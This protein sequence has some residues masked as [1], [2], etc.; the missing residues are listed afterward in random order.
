VGSLAIV[1]SLPDVVVPDGALGLKGE[2]TLGD[3]GLSLAMKV[4]I[5]PTDDAFDVAEVWAKL[6]DELAI[7]TRYTAFRIERTEQH[8]PRVARVDAAK[9]AQLRTFVREHKLAAMG[10]RRVVGQ[11]YEADF[12]RK[13]AILRTPRGDV[14]VAFD[15]AL[16]DQI[17][18][19]LRHQA[20]ILGEVA[21]DPRDMRALSIQARAIDRPE[22]LETGD[23]WRDEGVPL[24]T[25]RVAEGSGEY[26]GPGPIQGISDAEWDALY[27]ELGIDS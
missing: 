9:Q 3:M 5:Q 21:Y 12:I 26:T 16:E 8:G 20:T 1:G 19:T 10:E 14:E 17:Y 25:L 24:R 23:F 13:T 11:L 22:Q 18:E 6:G 2:T 15:S 27:R 4:A 7:G